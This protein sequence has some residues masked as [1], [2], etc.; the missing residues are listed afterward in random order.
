MRAH[1]VKVPPNISLPVKVHPIAT[2]CGV[3]PEPSQYAMNTFHKRIG[4]VPKAH[5]GMMISG[6]RSETSSASALGSAGVAVAFP[7]TP[8]SY[9]ASLARAPILTAKFQDGWAGD[10]RDLL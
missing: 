6:L 3:I 5:A 4:I 1:I 10:S 7:A 2:T 8:C 9:S